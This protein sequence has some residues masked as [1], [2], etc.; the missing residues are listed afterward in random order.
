MSSCANIFLVFIFNSVTEVDTITF[1]NS[2]LFDL[3]RSNI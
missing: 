1:F 2:L 3:V